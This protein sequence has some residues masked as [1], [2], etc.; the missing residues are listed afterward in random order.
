MEVCGKQGGLHYPVRGYIS[1]TL[2]GQDRQAL[3]MVVNKKVEDLAENE[4]VTAIK[5]TK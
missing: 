4:G 5:L 1:L 2:S 3:L